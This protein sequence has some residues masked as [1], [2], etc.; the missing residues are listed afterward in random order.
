[1]ELALELA[2]AEACTRSMGLGAGLAAAIANAA[3]KSILLAP[4]RRRAGTR[5]AGGRVFSTGSTG[6]HV[7]GGQ[8]AADAIQKLN[9][10]EKSRP[11]APAWLPLGCISADATTP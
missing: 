4:R 3:A 11:V 10:R 1:M 2:M 5:C 6:N 7:A 8:P 9:Q